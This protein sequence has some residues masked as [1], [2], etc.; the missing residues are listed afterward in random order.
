MD[1][2]DVTI[3]MGRDLPYM[4]TVPQAGELVGVGRTTAHKLARLYRES[5]GAYGI[6]NVRVGHNL[7][8][9]RDELLERIRQGRITPSP[10]PA[11]DEL[12]P[13]R[14]LTVRRGVRSAGGPS[15]SA[16]ADRPRREPPPDQLPLFPAG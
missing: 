14:R 3:R 11:A 13:R 1:D 8:V 4:L 9:P 5:G 7:R 16:R 6:P 2:M 12:A 10:A 15:A